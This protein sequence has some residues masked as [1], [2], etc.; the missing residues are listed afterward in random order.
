M[1]IT[2][3][4]PTTQATELMDLFSSLWETPLVRLVSICKEPI[5]T[6]IINPSETYIPGYGTN[7]DSDNFTL[8][9]V[10]QSFKALL[11]MQR[12][13]AKMYYLTQSQMPLDVMYMKV[14][15]DA[16][17]YILNGNRTLHVTINNKN[18]NIVSEE[19]PNFFLTDIYYMF[20]VELIK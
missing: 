8:T 7:S 4:I 2:D 20:R 15:Q 10:S 13:D 12:P 14:R 9:P 16:R 18:Y 17:D 1:P 3:L 5:K 11:V 6:P 19:T